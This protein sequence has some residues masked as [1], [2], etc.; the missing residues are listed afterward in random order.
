[1]TGKYSTGFSGRRLNTG[2]VQAFRIS[3][4]NYSL[5]CGLLGERQSE[6]RRLP[7]QATV[8]PTRLGHRVAR[9][10]RLAMGVGSV[11]NVSSS[12]VP[13]QS[14]LRKWV[15]VKILGGFVLDGLG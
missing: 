4:S 1:M 7:G 3:L 6:D 15:C 2:N 13:D 14:L 11:A 12:T 10:K 8:W 5:T 9:S